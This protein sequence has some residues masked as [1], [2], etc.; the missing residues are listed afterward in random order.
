MPNNQAMA[1]QQ[2]PNNMNNNQNNQ[3]SGLKTFGKYAAAAAVRAMA[4][5]L[6]HNA[7]AEASS[8]H[9]LLHL[10]QNNQHQQNTFQMKNSASQRLS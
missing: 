2:M 4:S 5:S 1:N 3:E 8:G 9:Q 6:Y 7:T 10:V